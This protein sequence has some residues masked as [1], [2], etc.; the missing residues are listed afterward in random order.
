MDDGR[1]DTGGARRAST[2]PVLVCIPSSDRAFC[3]EVRKLGVLLPKLTPSSLAYALH[4][5]Y[6]AVLVRPSELSNTTLV[7]RYVYSDGHYPWPTG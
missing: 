2:R 6:P 4:A 3:E 7:V 5:T 1:R